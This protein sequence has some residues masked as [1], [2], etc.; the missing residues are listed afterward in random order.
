VA[1]NPQDIIARSSSEGVEDS[2]RDEA[3]QA[4]VVSEASSQSAIPDSAF[5][6]SNNEQRP[7]I[8]SGLIREG[9]L[10]V[11]A[12][13]YGVG[14]SPLLSHISI[15]M[16]NGIPWCGH[17][18]NHR[19]VIAFDLESAGPTYKRNFAN[20]AERFHV[21]LPRIPAQLE[22]YLE[23]DAADA[24]ATIKLLDLVKSKTLDQRIDFIKEALRRKPNALVVIDPLE[25]LFR[26]D[27]RDKTHVLLL[28][29]HLRYLLASFPHSAIL[30]TLNLRKK[31]RRSTN[32]PD[33]LTDPRG[34]LEEVSGS[35]DILNRCDVRLGLDFHGED[36]RVINGVRRGEDMH[37]MLIRPVGE[38][39][40]G[41]AGFES[42][43]P[44]DLTLKFALTPTLLTYWDKLPQD[45][46]FEDMAD[47]I[48]PR[49][50]LHRLLKKAQSLTII[51]ESNSLWRKKTFGT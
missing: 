37:P 10:A 39:P 36:V 31:D 15:C 4:A 48:V 22:A 51:E 16:L 5:F 12:G 20:V 11:L 30:F 26:L 28:Y 21:Q 46:R 14:K 35:L 9:Q 44:T 27:T 8:V 18:V 17:E 7:E 45:F 42:C 6:T 50:T 13:T 47:R 38:L 32:Q 1:N 23:H 34:W 29:G 19:P 40:D 24:P 49:S 41:L 3:A 25:L 33:L 43:P 2:R